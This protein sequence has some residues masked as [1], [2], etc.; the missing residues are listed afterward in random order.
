MVHSVYINTRGV[1]SLLFL[2]NGLTFWTEKCLSWNTDYYNCMRVIIVLNR[3]GRA[4]AEINCI[5][6]LQRQIQMELD[7]VGWNEI[8]NK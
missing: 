7:H 8:T 4:S 2:A 5:K 6:E 3:K 1:N